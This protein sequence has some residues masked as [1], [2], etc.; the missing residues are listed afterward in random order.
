MEFLAE[1]V[2]SA[3]PSAA[4][5]IGLERDGVVGARESLLDAQLALS[6]S[7]AGRVVRFEDEWLWAT[8]TDASDRVSPLLERGVAVAADHPHLAEAVRAYAES[9]FSVTETARQLDLHP[10]SV[11][12]RLERWRS[13]TGWDPRTFA[14]LA[15]SLAAVRGGA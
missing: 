1:V 2:G 7:G 4:V 14:G 5:A 15:R 8:L 12:Y 13:L 11:A 6:V 3:L 9:G 10:N